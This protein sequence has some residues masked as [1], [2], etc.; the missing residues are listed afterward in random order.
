[1]RWLWFVSD[2]FN[3]LFRKDRVEQEL[4]EELRFHLEKE[5]DKNVRAG[6]APREARRLAHLRFGGVEQVKERVREERGVRPLE[7]LLKDVGYA[8]RTFRRDRSFAVITVLTLALG[9]G[10]TSAIFSVVNSVLL[11][12]LPFADPEQL[13]FAWETRIR[14]GG[15][16]GWVSLGNYREWRQLSTAFQEMAAVQVRPYNLTRSGDPLRLT[17]L[18]ATPGLLPLLGVT[19]ALGRG[20]RSDEEQ[21]GSEPV[22]LVSHDLWLG[23][24][25]A[26]PNLVGKRLT[27]DGRSH[28]V[29]GVLPPGFEIPG[30]GPRQVLTPV[31]LDPSDR[32]F[33][34]NHNS[35]VFARL[36]DG[37]SVDQAD[38]QIAALAARL[39]EE[40]PEWNDGIGARLRPVREQLVRGARANILILF[41]AVL[42]VLLLACVNVAALLLARATTREREM[43]MRAAL[44]AGRGRLVR[45]VLTEAMVLS[46][47]GGGLGLWLC[48][49]ALDVLRARGATVFPRMSELSLDSHVLVFT[50]AISALTALIFGL[51]PALQLSRL[52]IREVLSQSGR[53][54]GLRGK[55][56][57][58]R[59]LVV[60]QVALAS[61][62][63]IASG[64]LLRSYLGLTHVD[65]G[66]RS[67]NRIAMEVELPASRYADG[68]RVG[69]FLDQVVNRLEA[70]PWVRS[71]GA[72][73]SLPFFGSFWQ[74]HV[75]LQERP[76]EKLAD[77]PVASLTIATP[78]YLP[79]LEVPLRKGRL[80][81]SGDDGRA[82]FVALVNQRFV[83]THYRGEDPIGRRIRLDVPDHLLPPEREDVPPWY[84]IVGVVGDVRL[85]L[86]AEPQPEVIIP[87]LQDKDV[88]PEFLIVVH[89]VHPPAGYADVLRQTVWDIDPEQPVPWVRTLDDMRAASISRQRLN[90]LLVGVF[91]LTALALAVMGVYGLV[92]YS[93]SARTQEIGLRLALG[94]L[95][96]RVLAQFL[97]QGLRVSVVGV[98]IGLVLSLLTARGMESVLFGITARDS[99]SFTVAPGLLLVAA[100]LASFLPALR[101]SRSD[102]LEALRYE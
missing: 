69:E 6:M 25:A 18:Q 67:E 71:A 16:E 48:L 21:P 85:G 57:A 92:A 62:L 39:Q 55:I 49:V 87:Q 22:C 20:F 34:S 8:L 44:G 53:L 35:V 41:G 17:G 28:V 100:L 56:P 38:R 4:D 66:F 102:P 12:P 58:R 94:A 30:F 54:P 95:P 47:V 79:T 36:R 2:V 86:A 97:G 72:S 73:V 93:F 59:V 61:V 64:L 14:Q 10:A 9:I 37:L 98:A 80:L 31:V 74:K 1:M 89:A 52:Q 51:L 5:I 19:P 33:R 76:A 50:L 65:P 13:V 3:V 77:V 70:L 46:V 68:A 60:T 84:T 88:A 63:L 7:D 91:G 32:N 81:R 11:N 45:Q 75:T 83:D 96:S 42:L 26:D 43:A 78:G 15:S 99:L 29:V 101:A 23:R 90:L 27:L 24:F 40:Y 82:P